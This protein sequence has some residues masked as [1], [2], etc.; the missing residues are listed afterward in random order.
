MIRTI[1]VVSS[2]CFKHRLV[3]SASTNTSPSSIFRTFVLSSPTSKDAASHRP[4]PTARRPTKVC[5]PYGQG[6]R[7][8]EHSDAKGLLSTLDAG[9]FLTEIN[10]SD[11]NRSDKDGDNNKTSSVPASEI[12]SHGAPKSLAKEFFHPDFICGSKFISIVSA[13][14][15]NN[16]HYPKI[17]LERRLMKREKA[18]RVVT[19]VCCYTPTLGGLSFN[20]FHV[21]MLIDVEASRP[22]MDRI[23]IAESESLKKHI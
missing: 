3:G 11:N 10:S 2:K 9:W 7:P 14:A 15:H 17:S 1:A 6:G 13:V 19:K 18:W 5:D 12:I 16:N 8:L 20:D 21:A 22:E 23:L 4:D